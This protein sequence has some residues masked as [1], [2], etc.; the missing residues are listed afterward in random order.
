MKIEVGIQVYYRRCTSTVNVKH[1]M[2]FHAADNNNYQRLVAEF[3]AA[4]AVII[5]IQ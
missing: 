3:A 5:I 1:S 2:D 4:T